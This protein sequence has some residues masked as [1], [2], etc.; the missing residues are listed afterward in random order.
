MNLLFQEQI[1]VADE[2]DVWED[3]STIYNGAR[4][5]KENLMGSNRNELPLT[6][7]ADFICIHHSLLDP[8]KYTD[9]KSVGFEQQR[10]FFKSGF[11]IFWEID[12]KQSLSQYV[13]PYII[14]P[15]PNGCWAKQTK[16]WKETREKIRQWGKRGEENLGSH[17]FRRFFSFFRVFGW[18]SRTIHALAYY[19]EIY[20]IFPVHCYAS[21]HMD[22]PCT[23]FSFMQ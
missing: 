9:W 23:Y 19:W 22:T 18:S 20:S 1:C 16:N 11:L 12:R 5:R 10:C 4:R 7:L 14:P 3:G 8:L 13:V 17:F 2:Y 21:S 6:L 15:A